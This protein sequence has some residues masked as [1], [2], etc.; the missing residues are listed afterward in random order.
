MSSPPLGQATPRPKTG[1]GDLSKG[2]GGEVVHVQQPHPTT[3]ATSVNPRFPPPPP[4]TARASI[5]A[6]RNNGTGLQRT[7]RAL[8]SSGRH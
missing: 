3:K 1:V 2:G 4:L 6:P 8:T 5:S 7:Q